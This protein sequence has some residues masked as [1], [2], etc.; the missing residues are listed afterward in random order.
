MDG[1]SIEKREEGA[2]RGDT[3]GRAGLGRRFVAL[4]GDGFEGYE[5]FPAP[6]RPC[7]SLATGLGLWAGPVSMRPA[8]FVGLFSGSGAPPH[9]EPLSVRWLH[10]IRRGGGSPP[11]FALG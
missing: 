8:C 10:P 4:L 2:V 3:L 7:G 9:F 5:S 6:S 1:L 11:T